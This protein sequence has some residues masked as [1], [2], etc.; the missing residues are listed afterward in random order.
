[1][2]YL[3]NASSDKGQRFLKKTGMSV[4]G[5]EAGFTWC[6]RGKTNANRRRAK[7]RDGCLTGTLKSGRLFVIVVLDKG[8]GILVVE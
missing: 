7:W 3:G 1:M 2:A 5:A 8:D 4:D 6:G